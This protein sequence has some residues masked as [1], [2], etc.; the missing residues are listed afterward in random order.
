MSGDDASVGPESFIRRS[1]APPQTTVGAAVLTGRGL[2][3][4]DEVL[5]G[6]TAALLAALLHFAVVEA[7]DTPFSVLTWDWRSAAL[8]WKLPLGYTLVFAPFAASLALLSVTLP[9]GVPLRLSATIWCTLVLWSVALLF[10]AIHGWASLVLAL[11]V[12]LQLTRPVARAPGASRRAMRWVGVASVAVTAVARPVFERVVASR[13]RAGIASLAAPAEGAP[14]VLLLVWDTVRAASLSLYGAPVPTTP[15]LDSIAAHAVVFDEAH[16]TAPWTLPSHATLFTG[17]YASATSTDF[18]AGL[19]SD[20]P[21]L[22]EV[23]RDRGYVTAGFTANLMATRSESGLSRGFLRYE[24]FTSSIWEVL[25]STSITQADVFVVLLQNLRLGRYWR[26]W[27]DLV[28]GNFETH[29]TVSSHD[30]KRAPALARDFFAWHDS[31]PQGRPFF[32]FLNM[33]DAHDPYD[34]PP[35]FLEAVSGP[36]P[37]TLDR[38]HGSIRFV[39]DVT[40]R[41]LRELDRRGVLENTIVV[42]TS[43]HGE[44]FGEHGLTLHGNSLY[45]QAIHV[46]LLVRYPAAAP[47]GIRVTTPVTIRDVPATVLALAGIPQA[48]TGIEG[49]TLAN[50][51]SNSGQPTSDVVSE[52]SRH[53]RKAPGIRNLNGPM[54]SLV[55]DSLHV[56]RDGNDNLEVYNVVADAAET[57]DLAADRILSATMASRLDASVARNAL[58]GRGPYARRADTTSRKGAP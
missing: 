51:W 5:M 33:F 27:R 54:Q 6:A 21:T 32:A 26:I 45:R 8:V 22:A 49:H 17:R 10:P 48:A 2:R 20:V 31:I 53:Y 12:A 23:L 42:I 14:N 46:P 43:D 39:D 34:P 1:S 41:L 18:A 44:Q 11:A 35:E 25:H 40:G 15:Q 50:L 29:F 56:I 57:R 28:S 19:P 24:D 36:N 7:R 30:V 47:S 37:R 55:T 38:Y 58:A 3:A 9:R 4:L 13:E 52:V 16:S